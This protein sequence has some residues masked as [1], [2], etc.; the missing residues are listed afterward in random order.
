[1]S[2]WNSEQIHNYFSRVLGVE[3]ILIDSAESQDFPIADPKSSGRFVVGQFLNE[4]E[5]ELIINILKAISWTADVKF[6]ESLEEA[7]VQSG[8][9]LEFLGEQMGSDIEVE[10][11]LLRLR[12]VRPSLLITKPELKKTAWGL[13]QKLMKMET[14]N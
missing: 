1:M 12:L 8:V 9:V 5:R 4:G 6:V 11:D 13:L 2:E 14:L 10:R 3:S 7:Q